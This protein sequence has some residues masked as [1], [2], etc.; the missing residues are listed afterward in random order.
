MKSGRVSGLALVAGSVIGVAIMTVHPSHV[1]LSAP[2]EELSRLALSTRAVHAGALV[3]SALTLYGLV[4]FARRMGLDRASALAG[5]VFYAF[6]TA[7]V[8][9]AAVMSGFVAGAAIEAAIGAAAAERAQLSFALRHTHWLNSGY[10][11]VFVVA[12]AAGI[13]AWSAGLWRAG[14]MRGLA[15][16]GAV[17]GLGAIASLFT[18]WPMVSVHGFLA[19][20]VAQAIW[21]ISVGLTLMRN[22][23]WRLES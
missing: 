8:L 6:G 1:D 22:P 10:A 18:P 4:D 14:R 9:S 19:L 3:G 15:G 20:V 7:A 2:A 5:L 12:S 13:L 17:V 23:D 11:L 21:T 16:V